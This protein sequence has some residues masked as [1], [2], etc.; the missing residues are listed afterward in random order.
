LTG[1]KIYGRAS[2]KEIPPD[3]QRILQSLKAYGFGHG[4]EEF[5]H[6]SDHRQIARLMKQAPC[7]PFTIIIKEELLDPSHEE[8]RQLLRDTLRVERDSIL[9]PIRAIEVRTFFENGSKVS[10]AS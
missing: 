5:R 2:F 8:M 9:E 1:I 6:A 10:S 4:S 3:V 7:S